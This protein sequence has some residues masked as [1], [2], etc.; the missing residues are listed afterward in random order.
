MIYTR[1]LYLTAFLFTLTLG[2]YPTIASAQTNPNTAVNSLSRGLGDK[3]TAEEARY[4]IFSYHSDNKESETSYLYDWESGN[5]RFEGQTKDLK[6]LVVLFNTDA[7]GGQV[8]VDEN[9]VT[10]ESLL[11]DVRQSFEDD[12]YFLFIP[13]L[14]AKQEINTVE[15]EPEIVDSKK[16]HVLRVTSPDSKYKSSKIYVDFQDGTIYKWNTYDSKNRLSHELLVS[17]TKDLGGGLILPTQFTDK[18]T[19]ETFGYPIAAALL[20]IEPQKFK[21]P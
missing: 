10:D 8:F 11:K 12:S 17:Q 5:C 1:K 9:S 16:F 19:G 15:L 20:N 3:S 21:K 18:S 4:L 14:I 6:D 2:L 13:I 7:A